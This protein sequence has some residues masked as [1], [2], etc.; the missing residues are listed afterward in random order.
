MTHLLGE[1]HEPLTPRGVGAA[2]LRILFGSIKEG[3]DTYFD[4]PDVGVDV[5]VT[6]EPAL[7]PFTLYC[8][9]VS[10]HRV[11]PRAA[12]HVLGKR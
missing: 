9:R 8:Y 11:G 1:S 4:R 6:S 10:F 2:S 12:C 3:E 5:D 7:P